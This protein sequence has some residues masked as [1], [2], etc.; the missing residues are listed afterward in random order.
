[1]KLELSDVSL[2]ID[3]E[4][5]LDKV[6]FRLT[7]GQSLVV[8]GNSGAGKSKLLEVIAGIII[9]Q[10]GRIR[11]AGQEI[12]SLSPQERGIGFVFQDYALFPHLTVVENIR[13]GLHFNKG[14]HADAETYLKEL[15][16]LLNL[17]GLEKRYPF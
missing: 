11:F 9:N 12:A 3:R 7:A 4:L 14:N 13:Y 16:D 6:S 5:I 1:M 10:R 17:K 8:L 2:E 15:V